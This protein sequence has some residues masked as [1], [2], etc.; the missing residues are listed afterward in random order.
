[1]ISVT[2]GDWIALSALILTGLTMAGGVVF[3]V[4]QLANAVGDLAR[5]SKDLAE[6]VGALER[7][8]DRRTRALG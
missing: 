7:K 5:G 1:M 4:G 3:K 6:R 8:I 2:A